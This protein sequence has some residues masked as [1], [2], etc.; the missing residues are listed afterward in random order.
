MRDEEIDDILKQASAAA[1]PT[2]APELLRRVAESIRPTLRPVRPLWP[3]WL[4]STALVLVCAAVSFVG[5][6]R[7]GLFGFAKMDSIERVF[8]LFTLATLL[9]LFARALVA[10]MVP[11][12]PRR[13]SSGMLLLL[14]CIALAGMF[15]LLFHD[16]AIEQ[17]VPIGI[18]CLFTGMQHAIPAAL[19]SWLIVRRGFAINPVS[20]GL[21]AGALGGIAGVGMLELHCPNFEAAHLLVWHMAVVPLS[22]ALGAFAGWLIRFW[23]ARSA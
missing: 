1:A 20:A 11:A 21:I 17:F 18:N 23:S 15:A 7:V 14:A 10:E 8:I 22:A 5:A 19:L 9:T 4:L 3:A 16:Y 6:A 2:P 12:T 13:L